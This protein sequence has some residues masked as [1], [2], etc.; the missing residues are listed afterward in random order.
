MGK[1]LIADDD[2]LMLELLQFKLEARDHSVLTAVDGEMALKLAVAARP[3]LIVLDAMMPVRDGFVVLQQLKAAPETTEIPVVMLTARKQES[4]GVSGL[5]LGA[6]EY[7][8]KPF[9]PEEL[10]TRIENI[11]QAA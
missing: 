11:L 10:L 1:I 4:D 3:D 9:M 7:L 5:Q 6:R 8:V 2:E